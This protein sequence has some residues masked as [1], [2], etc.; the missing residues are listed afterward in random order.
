MRT[1]SVLGR[2][3]LAWTLAAML[4]L[5]FRTRTRIGI[6]GAILVGYWALLALVP[7]SRR[8]GGRRRLFDGGN[9]RGLHRPAAAAGQ[10]PQQDLR[11]RGAAL[12]GAGRR[13]GDAR[14]AHRRVRPP[15]RTT[16]LRQS[17]GTL[18][19]AGRCRLHARRHIVGSQL[20]D[21]QEAVD[22]LVRLRRRRILARHVRPLLL[23]HRRQRDTRAG[24]CR[25]R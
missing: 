25:S 22:Q 2:I 24:C 23:D 13:H 3:G 21:Q 6:V 9:D 5:N 20:P 7:R 18:Y 10:A 14:N 11:S 19:G 16:P 15:L 17:Q 8:S 12:H 4:F 1:A